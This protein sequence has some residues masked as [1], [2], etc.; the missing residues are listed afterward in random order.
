MILGV[1]GPNCCNFIDI[2]HDNAMRRHFNVCP[3]VGAG[4]DVYLSYAEDV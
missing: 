2:L 3:Q 1:S 4:I